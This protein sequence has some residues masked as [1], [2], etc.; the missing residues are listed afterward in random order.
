MKSW[1]NITFKYIFRKRL[2]Q[3]KDNGDAKHLT[4]HVNCLPSPMK[5][6]TIKKPGIFKSLQ[7]FINLLKTKNE[8]GIIISVGIKEV[9]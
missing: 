6:L 4:V 3:T 7:D 2:K 1:F 9:K 5:R 8:C